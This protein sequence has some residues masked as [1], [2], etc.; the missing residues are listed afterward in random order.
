MVE[1]KVPRRFACQLDMTNACNTAS[2]VDVSKA[3]KKYCPQLWRTSK[4]A[5]GSS[6]LVAFIG[7]DGKV[8]LVESTSGVRQ[9]DPLAPFFFSLAVRDTL[10]ALKDLLTSLSPD[11]PPPSSSPTSTTYSS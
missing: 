1:G 2:R 8:E 7:A 10:S 4:L 3:G 5:Y 11:S 9:G 6:T